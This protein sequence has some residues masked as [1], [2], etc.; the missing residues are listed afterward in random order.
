MSIRVAHKPVGLVGIAASL[1]DSNV[2]FN[3]Y[4]DDYGEEFAT[5]GYGGPYATM[6][7][8]MGVGQAAAFGRRPGGAVMPALRA[9]A[10]LIRPG[11]P[12]YP[13]PVAM[14][15]RPVWRP[16]VAPGVPYPNE[17]MQPLPLVPNTANGVFAA[18]TQTITFTARPQVPFRA[19]RLLVTVRRAGA[20][21]VNGVVLLASSFFVG[22]NNQLVQTG[23]FD[24]EQFSATAFGV[25]LLLDAAEPGIEIA[26]TVAASPAVVGT[27][28]LACAL[29]ILGRSIR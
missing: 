12:A 17:G 19:E 21:T 23:S 3:Y 5:V 22:R 25:R 7:D 15:P 29:L 28:T 1:A 14:P 11:A 4:E 18:A 20:A 13:T 24:I 6:G 16:Q 8:I 26:M 2:A 9:P 27:D 10:K